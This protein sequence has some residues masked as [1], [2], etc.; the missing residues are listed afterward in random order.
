M[1]SLH[2]RSP[3]MDKLLRGSRRMQLLTSAILMVAISVCAITARHF[4]GA[5][6]HSNTSTQPVT[7]KQTKTNDT[8]P[9]IA[10]SS[11]A[12][13]S[14][15]SPAS[16]TSSKP[17]ASSG[18]VAVKAKQTGSL[19]LSPSSIVIYKKPTVPVEGIKL[20]VVSGVPFQI[21]SSDGQSI[22]Y[23]F[24][25]D[26]NAYF[27]TSANG[28]SYQASWPMKAS[29]DQGT[30][31]THTFTF[32][33]TSLDGKTTYSGKLEVVVKPL[34]YFTLSTTTLQ[35]SAHAGDQD[36]TFGNNPAFG[37][38]FSH[39]GSDVP[40][41]SMNTQ[42]SQLVRCEYDLELGPDYIGCATGASLGANGAYPED[43]SAGFILENQFQRVILGGLLTVFP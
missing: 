39:V 26:G 14:G 1:I 16:S 2:L 12:A 34:P 5:S 31:G 9:A 43:Y 20:G 4:T 3:K 15:A 6:V 19:T 28:A 17:A 41:L 7:S 42:A 22:S 21:S 11:D 30:L 25:A 27:G 38:D 36:F 8:Q 23:P 18:G 13:P 24:S 10:D 40:K 37:Y 29:S 35:A 33:A 32:A